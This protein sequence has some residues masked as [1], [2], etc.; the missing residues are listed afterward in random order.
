MLVGW[1]G[2]RPAKAP[3]SGDHPWCVYDSIMWCTRSKVKPR[4]ASFLY[5]SFHHHTDTHTPTLART[6]AR[7]FPSC[8][9]RESYGPTAR[10]TRKA[11]LYFTQSLARALQT[12]ATSEKHGS[13]DTTARQLVNQPAEQR[14]TREHERDRV[15]DGG[16]F[17]LPAST[18]FSLSPA[19]PRARV[20][21]CV[22][23]RAGFP[24]PSVACRC[25]E[26]DVRARGRKK[27]RAGAGCSGFECR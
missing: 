11:A 23:A 22:C 15:K 7:T 4:P 14:E 9:C 19:R 13:E 25:V 16:R 10:F 6:H 2:T 20:C 1:V 21:V 12:P 24:R 18:L 3:G 8:P 17:P 27:K 5:L 26:E